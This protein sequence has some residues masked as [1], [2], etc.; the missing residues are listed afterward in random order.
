M[1]KILKPGTLKTVSCENC[2]ALLQ[3][4][5]EDIIKEDKPIDLLISPAYIYKYIYCPQCK[6]KVTLEATR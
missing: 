6:K 3:Y 5:G 2:G 1:I 4:G